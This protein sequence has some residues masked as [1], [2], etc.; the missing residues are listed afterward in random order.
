MLRERYGLTSHRLS[1]ILAMGPNTIKKYERGEIPAPA[2]G[3]M[4][5]SL[6]D[7]H[8]FAFISILPTT[9]TGSATVSTS[10]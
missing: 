8:V 10:R 4:I 2:L 7:D 5:L 6:Y 9:A 1:E 3:H